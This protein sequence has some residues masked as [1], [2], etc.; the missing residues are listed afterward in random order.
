MALEQD[1]RLIARAFRVGQE[2]RHGDMRTDGEAVYHDGDPI[3]RR[4]TEGRFRI[5]MG[6]D[7]AAKNRLRV[8]PGRINR[9]NMIC[10]LARIP[11]EAWQVDEELVAS[12][13]DDEGER[14]TCR[15]LPGDD[16]C[17]T[18]ANAAVPVRQDADALFCRNV[19]KDLA[20]YNVENLHKILALAK[21]R[22]EDDVAVIVRNEILEREKIEAII[23]KM[24]RVAPVG[25]T[26]G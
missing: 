15:V 14:Y 12:W 21:N 7:P 9:L 16:I 2:A 4:I 18:R 5:H 1:C 3:I 6:R 17:V 8:K 20:R 26:E 24:D 23:R 19:K 22:G 13:L 25:A 10:K 11:F